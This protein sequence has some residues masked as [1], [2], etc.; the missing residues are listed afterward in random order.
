MVA[1]PET[2]A[3]ALLFWWASKCLVV[4]LPSVG[5]LRREHGHPG[6]HVLDEQGQGTL[7]ACLCSG[8][9]SLLCLARYPTE[10]LRA[11]SSWDGEW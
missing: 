5:A 11:E 10:C 7:R 4:I 1:K 9:P 3:T 6:L 8:S 2:D